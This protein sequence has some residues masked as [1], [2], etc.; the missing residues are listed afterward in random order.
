MYLLC[1]FY[2]LSPFLILIHH[3][4][5]TFIYFLI[6]QPGAPGILAWNIAALQ[7]YWKVPWTPTNSTPFYKKCPR[8]LA[9]LGLSPNHAFNLTYGWPV[10][11][12]NTQGSWNSSNS[13]SSSSS[14]SSDTTCPPQQRQSRCRLGTEGP[15]CAVCSQNYNRVQ[16]SCEKC[17]PVA[18]RVAYVIVAVILLSVAIFFFVRFVRKTRTEVRYALRDANRI[19]LICLSLS[20]INVTV[21]Q[22]V[23]IE[24]PQNILDFLDSFDWVN[25]DLTAIT[26][27]TCE[28]SVDFRFT[29]VCMACVPILVMVA[30]LASYFRGTQLIAKRI[31]QLRHGTNE[32]KRHELLKCYVEIFRVVD[33]DY[34]GRLSAEEFVDLL[35]LVGYDNDGGR[36]TT[37][38]AYV[39]C[40]L[41]CCFICI[42]IHCYVC[43]LCILVVPFLLTHQQPAFFTRTHTHIILQAARHSTCHRLK[44][45]DILEYEAI[46]FWHGKW[47]NC[48]SS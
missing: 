18:N 22:V 13:S 6:I 47:Y 10:E 33:C 3:S 43:V 35:K 25:I 44:F 11:T 37:P 40:L 30:A 9:C 21:P 4:Y 38:I 34:S 27:A 17:I 31:A 23:E 28:A 41:A 24:W 14:G 8:K 7:G 32:E 16:G 2:F 36:L 5:E 19:L 46:C 12:E 26:G 45:C 39:H 20:Q 42:L 48:Q 15:L 29:F 1:C